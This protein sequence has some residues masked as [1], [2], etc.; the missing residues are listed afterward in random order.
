MQFKAPHTFFYL[1]FKMR[2]KNE[3]VLFSSWPVMDLLCVALSQ[4]KD[5]TNSVEH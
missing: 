5:K 3:P 1:L 2:S 4:D